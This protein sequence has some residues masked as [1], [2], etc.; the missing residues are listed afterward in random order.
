MLIKF[1]N[2]TEREIETLS[3]ANLS[4]A[5]LSRANLSLA[6]LSGAYLSGADLSGAN[7]SGANLSRANLFRANL[8]DANLFGAYLS[9]ANLSRADLSGADFTG[10]NLVGAT[11]PKNFRIAR[12]DFGGWSI[13]VRPDFTR[14]GCQ[15]HENTLWLKADPRW[16]AALDRG[17][18]A[19]WQRHGAAVQAL[20]RD[21]MQ[22]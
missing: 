9:R 13:C 18:S 14:I 20:I 15:C 1:L 2:G 21:V 17:A 7:L 8:S 4:D 10:A 3:N 6:N 12:L 11:L 22:E 19:W 16:I 5:N